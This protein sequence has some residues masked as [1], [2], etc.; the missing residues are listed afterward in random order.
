MASTSTGK[1]FLIIGATGNAGGLVTPALLER[2]ESVRCLVRTEEKAQPLR[3][4][5]AEVVIGDLEDP[6]SLSAAFAGIDT[7]FSVI[8]V[9]PNIEQQGKN[10]VE[11]AVNAKVDHFVR[12]ALIQNEH[13]GKLRSGKS[14]AVVDDMLR[15]SGLDYTIILPHSYM[16]NLMLAAATIQSDSAFYLPYG[17]GKV[18][19]MDLRDVA[20]VAVEALTTDG[21]KGKSYT[22][23]GP[24]SISMH[25][26]AKSLSK[27]IGRTI[28]YVDVP[29]QAVQEGML[30]FG[31][32]EWLVDE[33]LQY[34]EVFKNNQ[35][36]FTSDDF[37]NVMGRKPRSIDDFAR[38][39]VGVFDPSKAQPAPAG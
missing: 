18:G 8:A 21:H 7:V 10:L 11:A 1:K 14:Q 39:F 20:E 5:G 35:A 31:M 24:E 34:Y 29:P 23:T 15:N 25:E 36:N 3:D 22:I 37:E 9:S 32:G 4:A 6:G 19:L 38:D 13:I 27:A 17:T 26:V 12:Y 33:Y 28:S 30:A 16:Q 2:G